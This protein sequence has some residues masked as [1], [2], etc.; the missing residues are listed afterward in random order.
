[1]SAR[2][3][4]RAW[5][6][7]TLLALVAIGAVWWRVSSVLEPTPSVPPKAAPPG[8]STPEPTPFTSRLTVQLGTVR[9]R[10]VAG[11][12]HPADLKPAADAVLGA[13][14]QL[15][16][17]G[18]VDPS[19]WDDGRFTSLPNLFAPE[20][21][22]GVRRDLNELTLGRTAREL[23]AVRPSHARL[24]VT[25]L[26]DAKGR[27]LTAFSEMDF[28]GVGTAEQGVQVPVH[29]AGDFVLRRM[30]GRW[31]IVAYDV[32]A[33]VPSPGEVRSRV[34]MASFSPDVS[35]RGPFFLLV[36]GSDARPGQSVAHTRADSLHIVAFNPRLGR[37][38]IVGIPRDSFVAISGLGT[39]KINSALPFG[40]PELVV[41]TVERLSGV[42]IDGYVL[43]GFDG[44][45]RLINAIGG[46]EVRIPYPMNDPDSKAHFKPGPARLSGRRALAF[47]RDRH[48]V[49]GG[50]F[51]RSLNQGRV[52]LAALQQLRDHFGRDPAELLPWAI[53][54][55]TYLKTDLDLH[56]MVDLL[57]EVT[58]IPPSRIRNKVVS[59]S[60]ATVHGQSIVRLGSK[61]A[62]VFRD[63]ARDGVLGRRR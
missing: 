9:G 24:D 43:T 41:K 7:V 42:H 44:F 46:L 12:V 57:V 13:M 48:D 55:A 4:P 58:S 26:V 45:K 33:R 19:R 56:E 29:H 35:S 22:P 37:G 59:G 31:Q 36:I 1:M 60:G 30:H 11:K 25:F 5:L 23:L 40:G 50:D 61:A 53:A 16:T 32:R 6:G 38:T 39:S 15:Y 14:T 49:P 47:S 63:V 20:A 2:S 54:G 28:E 27:P 51:G 62:A 10:P 18:F 34:R 8:G 52:M 21:R 3:R 17:I